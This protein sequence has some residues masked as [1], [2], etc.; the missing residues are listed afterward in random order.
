MLKRLMQIP[1]FLKGEFIVLRVERDIDKL[2]VD[3][4]NSSPDELKKVATTFFKNA[5]DLPT[6]SHSK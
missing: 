6:L 5:Y 4:G 2:N 1:S 3:A